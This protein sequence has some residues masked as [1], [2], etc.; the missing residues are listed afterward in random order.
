LAQSNTVRLAALFIERDHAHQVRGLQMVG[1]EREP[2]HDVAIVVT[3]KIG[4]EPVRS[5][6]ETGNE[7]QAGRDREQTQQDVDEPQGLERH[8]PHHGSVNPSS[9]LGLDHRAHAP[10]LPSTGREPAQHTP[11]AGQLRVRTSATETAAVL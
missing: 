10:E 3:I 9:G 8:S 2:A 4:V 1:R 11:G 7:R 6:Q 5:A